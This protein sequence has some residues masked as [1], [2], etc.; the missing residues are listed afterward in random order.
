MG[1]A[2]GDS[3]G[4]SDAVADAVAVA[5]ATGEDGDLAGSAAPPQ[6]T[7]SKQRSASIRETARA[8]PG[9]RRALI[10]AG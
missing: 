2:D 1:G 4:G 9:P 8:V 10:M 7:M 5:V 6:A 3:A